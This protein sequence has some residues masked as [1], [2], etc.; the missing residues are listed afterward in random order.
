MYDARPT[1]WL[2]NCGCSVQQAEEFLDQ[3][4]EQALRG[5]PDA[6]GRLIGAIG[7]YLVIAGAR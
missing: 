2:T 6:V 3:F 4:A 7:H 5:E 1:P